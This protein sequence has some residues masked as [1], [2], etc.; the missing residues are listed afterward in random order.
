MAGRQFLNFEMTTTIHNPSEPG[1]RR[2]PTFLVSGLV[3]QSP[4]G[5]LEGLA[6]RLRYTGQSHDDF[7]LRIC[8]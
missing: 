6:V 1:F 7:K 3:S 8:R 4:S 2:L 5:S